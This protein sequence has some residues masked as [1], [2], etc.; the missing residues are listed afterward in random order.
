MSKWRAV[1]ASAIGT[2]H[3]KS[4]APCQD[5]SKIEI[6]SDSDG[7]SVLVIVVSDGAGSAKKAD[8][9]SRLICENFEGFVAAHFSKGYKVADINSEVA[10]DWI[11]Q[12]RNALDA[13]ARQENENI[14]DYAGTLLAAVLGDSESVFIHLGDGAIVVADET[15]EW[16]WVTWPQRGEFANTTYFLTDESSSEKVE[17]SIINRR[18]DEVAIFTDGI[19]PLVLHYSSKT[20]HSPFFDQMFPIVRQSE[21]DG[22]NG[23]L[24]KSLVAYLGSPHVCERTDDDKTLVLATRRLKVAQ[25]DKRSA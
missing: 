9:G 5:Y 12:T 8:V 2:S 7:R 19:E 23:D 15:I 20:V 4:Q 13:W 11:T 21:V 22:Y 10:K 25:A 14:K 3:S 17:I 24:S 6:L 16:T 1:A 18:I